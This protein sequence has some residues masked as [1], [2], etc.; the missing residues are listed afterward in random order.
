MLMSEKITLVIAAW[1]IF[2]LLI[3]RDADLEL[4]FILIILGF[5]IVKEFTDRYT[6]RLF[7]LKMNAFIF[8]FLIAFFIIIGTRIINFFEF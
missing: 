4:F 8:V 1:M 2:L 5:V 7:K 3:I 6:T